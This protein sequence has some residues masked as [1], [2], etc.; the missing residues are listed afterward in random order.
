MSNPQNYVKLES[1]RKKRKDIRK[2]FH[3]ND[4]VNKKR[5]EIH[6]KKLFPRN[7]FFKEN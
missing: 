7:R 6:L 5:T 3:G 4:L 2:K 1:Y